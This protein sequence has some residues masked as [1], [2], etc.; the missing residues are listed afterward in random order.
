MSLAACL[1]SVDASP[2]WQIGQITVCCA[3]WLKSSMAESDRCYSMLQHLKSVD[4]LSDGVVL[5]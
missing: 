4:W 2:S 5:A 1:P 3:L